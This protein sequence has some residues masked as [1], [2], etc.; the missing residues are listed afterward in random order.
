MTEIKIPKDLMQRYLQDKEKAPV[1]ILTYERLGSGWHGTGYRIKYDVGGKTKD[2]ILRTLKPVDFSHDY[3]SDRA[4]VFI[5]QHELSGAIPKHITSID[6][7]GYANAGG[8]ELFSLGKAKEFFQIVEVA[9]GEP[10]VKDFSRILKDGRIDE[11]DRKK[12]KMLSDYLVDLHDKKFEGP[13]EASD[14]IRRRH[15]R[16]AIGHGE[17]MLGVIDT[18]PKNKW[19]SDGQLTDLICQ[20]ARFREKV[21]DIPFIPRRMHGD[22][23]PANVM[24]KGLD[25]QV[26]DASRE[27]YGDPA[28]D[29]TTMALNYI[30]FAVMQRGKF[31][32]SFSE[33]F[34]VYWDNYF[35]RT[36]DKLVPRTAALY[37][38]FR[39]VVVVHPVFYKDQNNNVRKK[40]IRFASNVL[41]DDHFKPSKINDYLR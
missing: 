1:S 20:A 24:F 29:V 36:K 18:Y 13:K 33:L 2:V 7:G 10:Y 21:K 3:A 4:K 17:M 41:S 23:H 22:F 32:G 11:N 8:G 14:S 5:L 9:E 25:F 15:S 6:V 30:W 26:L 28:D 40:M 16:D 19:I 12:A 31:D 27:M 39:C 37:F 38:A 34:K 35:S